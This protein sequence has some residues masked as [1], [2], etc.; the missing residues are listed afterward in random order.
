MLGELDWRLGHDVAVQ[1]TRNTRSYPFNPFATQAESFSVLCAL[2]NFNGGFSG[3]C[4]QI[5]FAA[6]CRTGHVDRDLAVQVVA[7]AFE[8]IVLAQPDFN[9]QVTGRAAIL[10]G[11]SIARAAYT[12]AIIDARRDFNFKR[13]IGFGLALPM[14]GITGIR[15]DFP[16]AMA[17]W[18]GLLHTKEALAHL[19]LARTMARGA[20]FGLRAGL[21]TRAIAR[22][23]AIP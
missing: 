17:V 9:E 6:K 15:N 21:G 8:Y 18:A 19:H 10:A 16:F 3:E 13:F 23:A 4:W 11:L 7:I 12:H 14:A 2:W 5:N 20:G 22:G 1:I